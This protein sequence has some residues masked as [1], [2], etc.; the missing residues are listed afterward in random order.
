MNSTTNVE[1][2]PYPEYSPMGPAPSLDSPAAGQFNSMSAPLDIYSNST[3]QVSR[4]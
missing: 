3:L 4:K 1:M 2:L